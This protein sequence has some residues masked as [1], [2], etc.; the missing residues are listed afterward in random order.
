MSVPG[1]FFALDTFEFINKK[2]DE[3]GLRGHVWKADLKLVYCSRPGQQG[4]LHVDSWGTPTAAQMMLTSV[5]EPYTYAMFLASS[6]DWQH[7]LQA[8][9]L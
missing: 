5:P 6:Y 1:N 8:H 9:N 2:P 3:A 7:F 4:M